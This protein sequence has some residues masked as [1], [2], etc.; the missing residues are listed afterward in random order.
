M[1]FFTADTHFGHYNVIRLCNRPFAGLDE[2]NETMISNWNERVNANDT[3]YIIGDMF[4]RCRE[5]ESIL[6][7]LRGKKHLIVG[8]HDSS[9]MKEVDMGKYFK[10]VNLMLEMSDGARSLVLCHYPLLTWR[11][12]DRSYMIHG[13]IHNKTHLDFWPLVAA[14]ENLLNAGA[15]I[16]AFR[17]VTF[18]ELLKNNADFKANNGNSTALAAAENNSADWANESV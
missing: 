13:H 9:W 3:V 14:R 15:D 16:N 8:N 12:E 7:R 1:I 4:Y 10:S 6:K 2:M 11:R 17:P 5:P 18:G